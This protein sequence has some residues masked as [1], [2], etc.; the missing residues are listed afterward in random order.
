MDRDKYS[1]AFALVVLPNRNGQMNSVANEPSHSRHPEPCTCWEVVANFL[2]GGCQ[3]AAGMDGYV[4][5]NHE[6][7]RVIPDSRSSMCKGR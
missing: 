4:R 1:A 7:Q 3:Y 5:V 2:R 6:E